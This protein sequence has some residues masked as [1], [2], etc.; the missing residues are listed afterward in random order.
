[1]RFVL[2][3]ISDAAQWAAEVFSRLPLRSDRAPIGSV[4]RVFEFVATRS[5]FVTQKKLYGYLKERIGLRY[6]QMF[7]DAAFARSID[8]AKMHVF[9]AA[10]SDLTVFAVAQVG[11]HGQ[12]DPE[13]RSAIALV[14]YKSGVLT[15][16][17]QAPNPD[18]PLNWCAAF[19]RRVDQTQWE[20]IAAGASVFTESPKALIRWAPIADEHKRYDREIVENSMRFAWNEI[21]QDFRRRLDPEA[22][23]RD[24]YGRLAQA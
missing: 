13:A 23:V 11:A 24:W 1:M 18:A 9:A 22:V 15:N 19:E 21:V 3:Q 17:A 10:L 6:P 20:N 12:L 5:A 14:C 4:D 2:R 16:E 8:V 7:E